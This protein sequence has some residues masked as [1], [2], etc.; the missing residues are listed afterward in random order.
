MWV[1]TVV[2]QDSNIRMFQG[3]FSKT[4]NALTTQTNELL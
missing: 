3:Q 4:I 1:N 2:L